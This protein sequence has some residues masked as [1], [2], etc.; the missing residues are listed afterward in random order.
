LPLN[1]LKKRARQKFEHFR[2][3]GGTN[4]TGGFSGRWGSW[5]SDGQASQVW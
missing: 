4:H 2:F 5:P 3:A 1:F